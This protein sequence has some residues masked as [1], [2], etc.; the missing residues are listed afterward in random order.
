[1]N[2]PF[3]ALIAALTLALLA[4]CAPQ[5]PQNPAATSTPTQIP[6]P[7]EPPSPT[8]IPEPTEE[9]K[10]AIPMSEDGLFMEHKVAYGTFDMV[11]GL[12]LYD[13]DGDGLNDIIGSAVGEGEVAWWRNDGGRPVSWK[14]Q[15]IAEL[16][17]GALYVHA[18][19]FDGDGDGDVAATGIF[20]SG[21]ITLW[22]NQGGNPIQW[23]Q[24][25]VA[26]E[27]NEPHGVF[28]E[29]L[30]SDGD[31]DLLGT[32]AKDN[33]LAWWKNGGQAED[34]NYI[35][36]YHVI[37]NE[38]NQTQ[39]SIA[40]DI[41]QDGAMDVLAS[42]MGSQVAWWR[43]LGGEPIQWDMQIIGEDFI[44][45]HWAEAGDINNDGY[46]DVI[47]AA[48]NSDEISVWFNDGANPIDWTKQVIDDQFNGA[49]TVVPADL[50]D[51]GHLDVI[52]TANNGDAI[53]WW[54]NDGEN[55]ITWEKRVIKSGFFGAWPL[56]AADMDNDG[57]IDVV[58][59]GDKMK[60]ILFWENSIYSPEE[61]KAVDPFTLIDS[62]L[63]YQEIQIQTGDGIFLNGFVY[64]PE[65]GPTKTPAIFLGHEA[66]ASH[67]VWNKFAP[68]LAD[69]GYLVLTIDFR[70]HTANGGNPDYATN[71]IDV[72]ASLDYLIRNG[73]QNNICIGSSMGGTGCLAAT[74]THQI[75]ALGMISSPKTI[76]YNADRISKSELVGLTIPKVVAVAE[77]DKALF[78]DPD[79]VN[80]ILRYFEQLAEP[81]T[82]I[83]D[84]GNGH[85]TEL[86]YGE[87]G[88]ELH[89]A[90]LEMIE[91]VSE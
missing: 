8:P 85:G 38:F 67:L 78:N 24:Q 42:S 58:G 44:N 4:A 32:I 29:D 55:P 73:Y 41:D 82:L 40:S 91:S 89:A 60:T 26:E 6:V 35:L 43:N 2:F 68:L 17:N 86:L 36:T 22:I 31:I 37:S 88:E 25:I 81:K 84:S 27:L 69:L 39:S 76:V 33:T 46:K 83:L 80:D 45:G 56:A 30:D 18:H 13:I 28:F 19:D 75:A 72:R 79:F 5:S 87:K 71:G 49:L 9:P 74:K 23:R 16:G 11:S 21:T 48:Y 14:K 77:N 90:L 57:D 15:V 52:A 61:P 53:T 7:T 59:G 62:Q 47:G 64:Q 70:G 3:K 50:D 66:G 1:M 51:D 34:G 65:G 63:A 12:S 10:P 54:R 20:E